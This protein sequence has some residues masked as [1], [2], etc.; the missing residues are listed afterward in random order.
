M[1]A[2]QFEE[3]GRLSEVLVFET[4]DE[5]IETLTA[6]AKERGLTAARFTAIGAFSRLTLMYFDWEAKKYLEIPVEEQVE[7]LI[8]NGD[9]ALDEDKPKVHAHVVVGKR[10]GTAWGGHVKEA[11][12]RPTLEMIIEHPPAHLRKRFNPETGLTL[13]D[14]S[15]SGVEGETKGYA[16]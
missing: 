9:V 5:V 11:Y 6:Y 8:F 1:K 4:G 12:V 16:S 7:A 2:T 14:P 3:Q 13:I 10:D 15:L